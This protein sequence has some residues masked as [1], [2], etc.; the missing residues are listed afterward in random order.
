VSQT[1]VRVLIIFGSIAGAVTGAIVAITKLV[2]ERAKMIVG[3]QSEMIDDLRKE[4]DRVK[5]MYVAEI[6]ILT[7]KVDSLEHEV[8]TLTV[9][10]EAAT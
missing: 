9:K 4:L 1:L 6:S 7:A 8:E 10:V 2:P 5:E 3:Y